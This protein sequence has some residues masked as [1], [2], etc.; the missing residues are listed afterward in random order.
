MKSNIP[1]L[2]SGVLNVAL[3]GTLLASHVG[4]E[5]RTA[6]ATPVSV[7]DASDPARVFEWATQ[8]GISDSLAHRFALVAAQPPTETASIEYWKAQPFGVQT[9]KAD[10][11][12]RNKLLQSFGPEAGEIPEYADLFKPYARHLPFLSSEKQLALQEIFAHSGDAMSGAPASIRCSS[13]S[14]VDAVRKLLTDEELFEYQLRASPL[15][16]QL[17]RF[18]FAYTETEFREVYRVLASPSKTGKEQEQIERILGKERLARFQQAQDP[19]YQAML[20]GASHRGIGIDAVDAAYDVVKASQQRLLALKSPSDAAKRASI[21]AE[22]DKQLQAK[23]G[24]DLFQMVSRYLEP[25][26]RSVNDKES[27]LLMGPMRSGSSFGAAS[28][29]NPE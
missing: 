8:A 16:D 20:Q 24:P 19:V 6:V 18:G 27:A 11:G 12:L 25:N 1:L 13:A 10:E 7:T 3:M 5:K 26:R 22:R 28:R 2:A 4:A 15:A 23:L 29:V 17:L 14:C 21:Y 9:G